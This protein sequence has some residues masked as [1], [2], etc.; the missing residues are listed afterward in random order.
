MGDTLSTHLAYEAGDED[1]NNNL[2]RKISE[3]IGSG[4]EGD[5]VDMQIKNEFDPLAP[6][7]YWHPSPLSMEAIKS[8]KVGLEGREY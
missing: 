3:D 5:P 4:N 2:M 6:H 7:L 8:Q 1:N